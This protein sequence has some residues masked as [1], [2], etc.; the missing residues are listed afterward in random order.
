MDRARS[1]LNCTSLRC[2]YNRYQSSYGSSELR[3]YLANLLH[4]TQLTS[5]H[6]FFLSTSSS[7]I[8]GLVQHLLSRHLLVQ[9]VIAAAA[10]DDHS[11]YYLYL[12]VVAGWLLDGFRKHVRWSQ[13]SRSHAR[14]RHIT[15]ARVF[16]SCYSSAL[17]CSQQ[18]AATA[19][20]FYTQQPHQT[21]SQEYK[22]KTRRRAVP[23][24]ISNL[25]D[26]C[27]FTYSNIVV[28]CR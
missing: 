14:R 26:S 4:S 11:L 24:F 20:T 28:N 19:A 10:V 27:Y 1:P 9:S 7:S 15:D 16:L 8:F 23:F 21:A 6:R 17:C 5:F 12:A 22:T 25:F 18:A 3:D 2:S 13:N